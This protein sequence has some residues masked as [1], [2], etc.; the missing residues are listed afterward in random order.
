M[1]TCRCVGL[2]LNGEGGHRSCWNY[3][4][5]GVGM[6][7]CMLLRD[8]DTDNVPLASCIPLLRIC[9]VGMS[10]FAGAGL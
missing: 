10:A 7:T 4:W 2:V 1:H 8:A 9:A 5:L 6:H 3:L